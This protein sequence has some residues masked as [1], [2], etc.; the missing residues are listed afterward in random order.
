MT[1]FNPSPAESGYVQSVLILNPGPAESRYV[2]TLQ[3][4]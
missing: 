1:I 3:T 4:V 2:L